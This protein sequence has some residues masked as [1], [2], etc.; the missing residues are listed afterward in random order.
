MVSANFIHNVYMLFSVVF[1]GHFRYGIELLGNDSGVVYA[2]HPSI[3]F[4][5]CSLNILEARD[6]RWNSFYLGWAILWCHDVVGDAEG[7]A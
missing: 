3:Y 1:F 7:F 4:G 6:C 5:N 2:Q